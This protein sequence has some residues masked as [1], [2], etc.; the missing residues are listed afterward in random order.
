MAGGGGGGGEKFGGGP[1]FPGVFFFLPWGVFFVL[2][3]G[4]TGQT[5][6]KGNMVWAFLVLKKKI[7]A[8]HEA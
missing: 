4:T 1:Y 5:T 8:R 6:I 3:G 2:V 7:N